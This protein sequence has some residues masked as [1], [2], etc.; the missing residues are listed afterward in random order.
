MVQYSSNT[1]T[2][3]IIIPPTNKIIVD[4]PFVP[5]ML[6]RIF[7]LYHV[8]PDFWKNSSLNICYFIE[9]CHN[10]SLLLIRKKSYI[11]NRGE[12]TK[13]VAITIRCNEDHLRKS[14]A[15]QLSTCQN[16]WFLMIH[17][18]L[19]LFV[20]LFVCLFSDTFI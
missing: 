2:I 10:E 13:M 17:V 3:W 12:Q 14:V 18:F 16:H 9:N 4:L 1:R 20:C 11:Y 8:F 6:S 15:R 5:W 7:N 19:C